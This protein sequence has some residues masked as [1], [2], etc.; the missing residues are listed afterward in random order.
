MENKTVL[1]ARLVAALDAFAK[2]P[3]EKAWDDFMRFTP[4]EH[5]YARKKAALRYLMGLGVDP[6][7]LFVLGSKDGLLPDAMGWAED[8]LVE[9]DTIHSNIY[10]YV[11][12]EMR[13]EMWGLAA[14]AYFH[15]SDWFNTVRCLRLAVEIEP[16]CHAVRFVVDR[17]NDE[18]L[19]MLEAAGII[20]H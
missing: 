13:A 14:A 1:P 18:L 3:S 6:N 11:S 4:L 15:R 16:G 10:R 12:A 5:L 19:R 9:P 2:A 8:G 20:E 7:L 17:A